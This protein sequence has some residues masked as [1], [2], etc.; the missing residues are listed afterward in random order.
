MIIIVNGAVTGPY[1]TGVIDLED[2]FNKAKTHTFVP[3]DKM[4][5]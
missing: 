3:P 4:G 5:H 2:N 1:V